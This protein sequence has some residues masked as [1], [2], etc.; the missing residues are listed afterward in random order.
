LTNP[1]LL[2]IRPRMLDGESFTSW[3]DRVARGVGNWRASE[4]LV[5]KL[6][7]LCAVPVERINASQWAFQLW[8][9]RQ[10]EFFPPQSDA[11]DET[12]GFFK[13]FRYCAA[14]LREDH[15]PYFRLAWSGGFQMVCER[16]FQP[17][18]FGCPGCQ[19][20]HTGFDDHSSV[21]TK[22]NRSVVKHHYSMVKACIC[23]RCGSDLRTQP[24]Y[25][26]EAE[27]PALAQLVRVQRMIRRS[28]EQPQLE[29][30]TAS[31]PFGAEVFEWFAFILVLKQRLNSKYQN[32]RPMSELLGIEKIDTS[33]TGS[34]SVIEAMSVLG[35]LMLRPKQNIKALI[36]ASKCES[37][38]FFEIAADYLG[39]HSWL[40]AW[41]SKQ[42][43]E[44]MKFFWYRPE[45]AFALTWRGNPTQRIW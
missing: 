39:H 1:K 31:T 12:R 38:E 15:T 32:P 21:M 23:L 25:R 30:I 27:R 13:G 40:P 41:L 24:A 17:L 18:Q 8:T 7:S 37:R 34:V 19:S 4:N 2:P 22:K 5:Q 45:Q 10:T 3:L 42:T 43:E 16:H 28:V 26:C 35:W 11:V 33:R 36:K 44:H 14:C 6:S 20:F 29:R 9:Q